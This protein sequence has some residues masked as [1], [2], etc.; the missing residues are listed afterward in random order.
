MARKILPGELSKEILKYLNEYEEDIE[1]VTKDL[2]TKISKEAKS[3]VVAKSPVGK[4][5]EYHKGWS[6]RTYKESKRYYVKIH[7]RSKYQLTH[8][9]E[10]GH[11]TRDGVSRTRKIPHVRPTEHKYMDKLVSELE[12][13]IRRGV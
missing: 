4:T 13:Q 2:T 8:L 9:L 11:V 3:E 7:N 5:G 6:V 10:F 1:E 12:K